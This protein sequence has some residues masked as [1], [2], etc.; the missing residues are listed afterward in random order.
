MKKTRVCQ[1]LGTEYPII[2]GGME[3][4]SNG[5]LVAAVA[6]AGALGNCTPKTG[7]KPQ[8]SSEEMA[9]N[10]RKHIRKAK[11]LTTK[12]FGV[13]ISLDLDEARRLMETALEE[14]VKVFTTSAGNPALHTRFLKDAGATVMHVT[15][16]VRHARRAEAEGVDIVIAAGFE[17]G[18]LISREEVTTLTLVPQVVDAVRVPVVAA[19]GIADARGLVAV[20]ALGAEGVQLGTRFMATPECMAHPRLKEAI[21]KAT[22]TDTMVSSRRTVPGRVLRNELSIKLLE[23]E[24][25]GATPDEVRS[26]RGY[27]RMQQALVEGDIEQGS[28]LCGQISGMITE[29]RT[30]AEIVRSLVEGAGPIMARLNSI[31]A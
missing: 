23:M 15:F 20:F 13:N 26:A 25:S 7:L 6:Q 11:S 5:E 12:P 14:G 1:L 21:L 4:I 18:G 3:Y 24:L 22:D 9:A 19:G 28:P 31:L 29:I 16:S 27:G 8:P 17:S 10:L 2:Q 30:A